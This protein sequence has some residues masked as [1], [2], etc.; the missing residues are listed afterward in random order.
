MKIE[1]LDAFNKSSKYQE[2]KF[3]HGKVLLRK[4]TRS[5]CVSKFRNMDTVYVFFS[6]LLMLEGILN[7]NTKMFTKLKIFK[8]SYCDRCK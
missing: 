8:T 1:N 4:P 3:S 7:K 2:I 6:P 5:F